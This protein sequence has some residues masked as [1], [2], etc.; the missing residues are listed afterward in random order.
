MTEPFARLAQEIARQRA[1]LDAGLPAH[2]VMMA[3]QAAQR[4]DSLRGSLSWVESYRRAITTSFGST[5][6]LSEL[7][8]AKRA[9]LYMTPLNSLSES[10]RIAASLQDSLGRTTFAST[11]AFSTAL[12]QQLDALA[13]PRWA[14]TDFTG[15]L[16]V[17]RSTFAH[18][19]EAAVQLAASRVRAPLASG[20]PAAAYRELQ[21]ALEKEDELQDVFAE[22][23]TA[24]QAAAATQPKRMD[25]KFLLPIIIAVLIFLVQW[26]SGADTE[27]GIH[28]EAAEVK[29]KQDSMATSLAALTAALG[30]RAV[31]A[32]NTW[33]VARPWANAART[34]LVPES[35]CVVIIGRYRK[36]SLVLLEGDGSTLPATGWLRQKYL[37][38]AQPR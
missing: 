34:A 27:E 33:L 7:V 24:L 35:S 9:Q 28:H 20:L 5:A 18:A 2:A 29:A 22:V 21:S 38:Y 31:A 14:Y 8:A 4:H 12:R 32:H 25:W 6:F 3:A 19:V 23:A 11:S 17:D 15:P 30:R 26:Q 36:W 16:G 37:R 10:M 13:I 1:S